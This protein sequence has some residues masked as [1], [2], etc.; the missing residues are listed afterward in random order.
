M[1]L[2]AMASNTTSSLTAASAGR[3]GFSAGQEAAEDVDVD[4]VA[5]GFMA[6]QALFS[7]LE[8]G[9][10]D[11]IAA[12]GEAGL[13][14]DDICKACGI[15]APR[16]QT[17]ITALT[18]MKSLRRSTDG[19][20]T[21]SPNTAKFLVQSSRQYYGDYLRYQIGQQFYKTMGNLPE[22]LTTGKAP[23]YASWF[24]DPEVAKTYTTAQHN[25]S[26]ATAKYLIKKKM[27]L[28][29]ISTML[30]VGGG[31]GAFSYVFTEATPGL[32][33]TVLELPEVCRTGE[34]IR[35]TQSE[36]VQKRVKFAELDATSPD[37]PVSDSSFDVVLMSYISGSVPEPVIGAL[38]KN[39]FKA[40]KPGGR[41]LVHD[42]MVDDSLDGPALGALWGLQHVTVNADGL[43]LCP[44]EIISRMASAG[45]DA[46]RC[47]TQEMIHGMTKLIVAH[48]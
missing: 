16:V 26:V 45:F 8:L 18:S 1:R 23:S 17:L 48:K 12:A 42:F 5:Y 3:R 15:N 47:E 39:A 2:M 10:F 7:G 24:S 40:L 38:Y 32:E 19:H 41:L 43:G 29:G 6:S 44:K 46:S 36:D 28:G 30:D 11:H 4:N 31:S 33:S 34:G 27:Q 14:A 22:V 9:M 37:W 35:A 25:G 21:L 20:Y 13:S